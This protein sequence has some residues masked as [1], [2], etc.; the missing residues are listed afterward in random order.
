MEL[1]LSTLSDLTDCTDLQWDPYAGMFIVPASYWIA[2]DDYRS[3]F[4]CV[5]IDTELYLGTRRTDRDVFRRYFN[6]KVL[7]V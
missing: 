7:N 6:R 3:N 2:L 4:S 5:L 1:F